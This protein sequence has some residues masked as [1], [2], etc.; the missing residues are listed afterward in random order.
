MHRT[1]QHSA[2]VYT[3]ALVG[4]RRPLLA[5]PH[6]ILLSIDEKLA[7]IRN[8]MA[9]LIQRK[10]RMLGECRGTVFDWY[11]PSQQAIELEDPRVRLVRMIDLR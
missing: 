8:Q 3:L 9:T 4:Q 5:L 11:T 7:D 6:E 10:W 2:Q 1:R